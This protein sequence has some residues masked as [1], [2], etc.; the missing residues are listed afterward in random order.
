[1]VAKRRDGTYRWPDR[2]SSGA[3]SMRRGLRGLGL[4]RRP[5]DIRRPVAVASGRAPSR[6]ADISPAVADRMSGCIGHQKASGASM[7]RTISTA[8]A[9]SASKESRDR[10]SADRFRAARQRA[11]RS[12]AE[13]SAVVNATWSSASESNIV[14]QSLAGRAA[15]T[16]TS[17][18]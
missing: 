16:S 10:P 11:T 18:P 15:S 17:T 9:A 8:D 2:E 6:R 7:S 5:C 3:A 14:A 4:P 12:H 13:V 1:M